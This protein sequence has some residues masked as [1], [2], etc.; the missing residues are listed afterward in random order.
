MGNSLARPL[1]GFA[2]LLGLALAAPAGPAA[3]AEV[4]VFAAASAGYLIESLARP[5]H[6]ATGHEVL[7]TLAASSTLARQIENGAPADLF[8][9]ANI[10]WMDYLGER[11]L[12]EPASRTDLFANR[13]ALITRVDNP[14][15]MSIGPG[16]ADNLAAA[17]GDGRL[18]MAD[19]AHVPVGLYGKAA[20]ESLGLWAAIA[21]RLARMRDARAVVAQVAR[22]ETP[23]GV[24]YASDA[25]AVAE[26]RVVA[27]FPADSHPPIV[28]PAALVAGRDGAPARALLR[29]L[30]S[31]E[32]RRAMR[33][34]GFT[35]ADGG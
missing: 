32:S 33:R 6:T 10:A 8:I 23:F 4:R 29:F 13:L 15:V 17:L 34:L 1:T 21:P 18:A 28:Y 20:F 26:V 35:A 12:I 16:L 9:S 2:V 7:L 27:I 19:P 30:K 11:G 5:F 24:A 3:A 31:A 14:A 22:G 25:A